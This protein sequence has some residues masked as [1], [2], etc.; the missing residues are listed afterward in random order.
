LIGELPLPELELMFSHGLIS[1]A[2]SSRNLLRAIA[3]SG[4][5]GAYVRFDVSSECKFCCFFALRYFLVTLFWQ[6]DLTLGLPVFA[7]L[8]SVYITEGASVD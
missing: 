6:A 1:T 4:D 3:V 8:F 7:V 5:V 2:K